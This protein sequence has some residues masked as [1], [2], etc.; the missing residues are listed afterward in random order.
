MW[1]NLKPLACSAF[2]AVL[3]LQ[4]AFASD[5][6]ISANVIDYFQPGSKATKFGKAEFIGGIELVSSDGSLGGWSALRL[7]PDQKH[8]VGVLDTGDWI[9]G[10]IVRDTAGKLSTL[11]DV[12][13]S[14]I[15]DKRGRVGNERW[16]VDSESV[17]LRR[18]QVLVGFER[19]YRI[20]AYPDPGFETARPVGSLDMLINKKQLEAN[21]STETVVV[22]PASGPLKGSPVTIMEDSLNKDGNFLAAVLEG[23]R[24]GIFYVK[25][26][27]AYAVTD[28]AFLPNGDLLILERRFGLTMGIGMRMRRIKADT[29]KPGATVDGDVV[30]EADSGY[31][32]DNMEGLEAFA[33]PDG[34][35]HVLVV[36]D[37]NFSL[38]QRTLMLEFRLLQ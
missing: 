23:P 32:I 37:D 10:A 5:R 33:A 26:K 4:P 16:R 3:M 24:K 19:A 30:L 1:R 25:K 12:R 17:A 20:D 35:T 11:S 31:Q 6:T 34:S 2:A 29:I 9:T 36:S 18:G 8:F 13:I 28:G 21:K 15:L 22:A 14:P 38:L 27:S 7:R